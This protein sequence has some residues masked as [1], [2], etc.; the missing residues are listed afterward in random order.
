MLHPPIQ[1]GPV[2]VHAY[3]MV[4]CMLRDKVCRV[5]RRPA[6]I[7][8]EMPEGFAGVVFEIVGEKIDII[9]R[10]L[11]TFLIQVM[12]VGHL[13]HRHFARGIL[14]VNCHINLIVYGDREAKEFSS[15]GWIC[16]RNGGSENKFLA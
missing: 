15:A 2:Q 9:F 8:P 6:K 16:Y 5:I 3:G 13:G 12:G 11:D 4:F 10:A 7:F 1:R 14:I